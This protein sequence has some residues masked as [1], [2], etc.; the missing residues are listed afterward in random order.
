M[1][2]EFRFLTF[3]L[4]LTITGLGLLGPQ[5]VLAASSEQKPSGTG[6]AV[7]SASD[8]PENE[9]DR[10]VTQ[11]IRQA[12][13]KDDSLSTSAQNVKIITQDGKVTLRGSV[14]SDNEKQKIADQAKKVQG[15][16]S[17]DNLITVDKK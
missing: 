10:K 17:V 1:K 12:I 5:T 3:Y 11:Q 8:Q 4:V 2:R 7:P 16:K 9:A 13:T 6:K 14:N 15:V